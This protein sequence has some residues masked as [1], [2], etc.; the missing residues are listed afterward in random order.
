M[1]TA[2]L[3]VIVALILLPLELS[4]VRRRLGFA[5]ILPLL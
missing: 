5:G 2:E 4:G 1:K 3:F